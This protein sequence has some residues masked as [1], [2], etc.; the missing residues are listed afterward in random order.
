MNHLSRQSPQ[1]PQDQIRP[2]EFA[3][4]K[5]E[6]EVR[7]TALTGRTLTR[8]VD[9]TIE[10]T[11]V[12]Q[13]TREAVQSQ[14]SDIEHGAL[15]E[16]SRQNRKKWVASGIS[17]L[18]GATVLVS[19]LFPPTLFVETLAVAI[20][21]FS[22]TIGGGTIAYQAANIESE[23]SC[24]QKRVTAMKKD[25]E[26]P[27]K[28]VI[29]DRKKAKEQGF[30][31]AF[32]KDLKGK[33]LHADEVRKLWSDAMSCQVQ[34]IQTSGTHPETIFSQDLLGHKKMDYAMKGSTKS[35]PE[36]EQLQQKAASTYTNLSSSY[37]AFM[38]AMQGQRT[39]LSTQV[40]NLLN[41]LESHRHQALQP[42]YFS[43]Q[44]ALS[45]AEQYKSSLT[46]ECVTAKEFAVSR[47]R[48]EFIDPL[49][50]RQA[51][52]QIQSE[53]QRD[54]DFIQSEFRR[55]ARMIKLAF[56]QAEHAINSYFD[57]EIL[58]IKAQ[59]SKCRAIISSQQTAGV[60]QFV[61]PLREI[62]TAKSVDDLATIHSPVTITHQQWSMPTH[63][64]NTKSIDCLLGYNTSLKEQ[65]AEDVWN[66]LLGKAGLTSYYS[67]DP[68]QWE[69]TQLRFRFD[70][71]FHMGRTTFCTPN[72]HRY[73]KR[74][75][76]PEMAH[77]PPV[78]TTRRT[79]PR[80][81]QASPTAAHRPTVQNNSRTERRHAYG[82]TKRR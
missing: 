46:R 13:K 81:Q 17:V 14:L 77:R 34:Q 59:A 43:K 72:K 6:G 47:A 33:S 54:L 31:Y 36:K 2:L 69:K 42:V 51:I 40:T 35:T 15:Q 66:L 76:S 63:Y 9:N 8:V 30:S 22:A 38:Q 20:I 29:D 28:Y 7:K 37:H 21:G 73:V 18:G 5:M 23:A 10:V 82:S 79:T 41:Q 61:E 49:D 67:I 4:D 44:R 56:S 62:F 55:D 27:I 64:Q 70:Q 25:W 78:Y 11:T 71:G 19:T 80:C 32:A 24:D 75:P 3:S 58:P 1:Y 48:N 16:I 50:R 45:Q 12:D 39:H 26:D 53:Y 57:S 65:I 52:Q 68:A 74:A 60:A